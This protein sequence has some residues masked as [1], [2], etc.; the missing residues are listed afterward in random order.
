VVFGHADPLGGRVFVVDLTRRAGHHEQA[1]QHVG[2]EASPEQAVEIDRGIDLLEQLSEG[3]VILEGEP[4]DLVVAHEHFQGLGVV[5]GIGQPAHGAVRPAQLLRRLEDAM[6][7]QDRVVTGN[8]RVLVPAVRLETVAQVL[9]FV[10]R[11]I[12]VIA[13]MGMQRS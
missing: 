5:R 13:G 10:F 9:E 7:G 8:H 2:I 12:L 4:G 3:A 11:M 1:H 6:A